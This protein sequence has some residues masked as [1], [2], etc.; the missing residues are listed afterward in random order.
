VEILRAAIAVEGQGSLEEITGRQGFYRLKPPP[1]WEGL[2]RQTLTTG[3]GFNKM[4]LVF[5]T[6]LVGPDERF[7]LDAH[8][9]KRRRS[10]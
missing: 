9:A 4:E 10:R 7:Q 8:P 5:E 6:A 2:A 1:K 3:S